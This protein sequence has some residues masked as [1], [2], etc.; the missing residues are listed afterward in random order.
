MSGNSKGSKGIESTNTSIVPAI[1]DYKDLNDFLGKHLCSSRD[2]KKRK[3]STNTRIGDKNMNIYGGNYHIP[4]IEYSVFLQLYYRDVIKKKR[5]EYLTEKQRDGDG[6]LVV[7]LDFRYEYNSVDDKQHSFTLIEELLDLY[8]DELKK[9]YVFEESKPVNA[10]VFEKPTLIHS[11]EKKIT[12]DGIHILIGLQC[13]HTVQQ[14][15]RKQVIK[16]IDDIF[17]EMPL[18]NKIDDIFDE[19]ISK[20][21]T[22]WQLYGSRKP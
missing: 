11:Q 16:N 2:D 22:N 18:T 13:D 7:D 19:G 3:E 21:T 6:P 5:K 1:N 9:I 15:L 14:I 8:F 12:K 17:E 4:D 10:Y 20:G